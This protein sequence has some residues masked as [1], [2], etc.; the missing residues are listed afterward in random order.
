[1][2]SNK[3]H[4]P[5]D[6]SFEQIKKHYEVE[7]AIATR[8]KKANREERK[9]I[10]KTMYDELFKQVPDH[11]RV[12]R[13]ENPKIAAL[14]NQRKFKLIKKFINKSIVFVEFGSGDCRFAMDICK[15]VSFVYGVD[16]SDQ[17]GQFDNALNNFELIIYDGYN[18]EMQENSA[19]V[20]F[21]D[22]LIEH[23]HPDDTKLHFQLVRNILK[24]QGIY[25]FRTPHRF[26]GPQDISCYF[27]D[28]AEG[29]HLKEWTYSEIAKILMSLKY[30]SWSG[31]YY[32]K[33]IRIKMPFV[34][35][36]IIENIICVIPSY[37]RKIISKYF[38][39][40]I[41]ILAVK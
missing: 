31:Y 22:N 12:K 20:V 21:S 7:K 33:G 9:I 15:H 1:M 13:R 5:S 14:E 3:K 24:S 11:P 36:I 4:L 17:R 41:T 35:F 30:S 39:P 37:L 6:R 23:L 38:L 2:K 29:F 19:D 28:E 10:Y 18:L 16:I 32:A 8:L 25:I 34:Y 40:N 27:S 26:S